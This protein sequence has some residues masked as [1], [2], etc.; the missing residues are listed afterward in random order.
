[1]SP[2][3]IFTMW[4][5]VAGYLDEVKPVREKVFEEMREEVGVGEE[6]ISS[7]HFGRPCRF[8]D[9]RMG[10]TWIVYP[11]LVE[12][13]EKPEIRLDWEH[14]GYTWI[15]PEELKDFDAVPNLDRS[16]GNILM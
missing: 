3:F 8:T 13:K 12:L 15:K 7:I 14:T 11:V 2:N 1:M 4:N 5:T 16:L 6:S 9:E 10:K